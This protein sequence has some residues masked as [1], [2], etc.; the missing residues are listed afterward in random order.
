[1]SPL[2]EEGLERQNARLLEEARRT[3]ARLRE[4]E[5][6]YRTLVMATSQI[7]WSADADGTPRGEH[8][9]W[10]DL[11]GITL[12]E[13]RRGEWLEAIHP[14]DRDRLTQTWEAALA[15]ARAYQLEF[16]VRTAQGPYRW[17][18]VRGVPVLNDDG[19]IREWIGTATDIDDQRHRDDAASFLADASALLAASLD[20][21]TILSRLAWLAVPRLA[22]WCAID[23]AR[24]N[25][26]PER[27]IIAHPDRAKAAMITEIDRDYPLPLGIDPITRVITSGK[28]FLVEHA[29]PKFVETFAQDERHL[30]I[31][32]ALGVRSWLIVPIV[33][34][35]RT[36]GSLS[37]LHTDSG[38]S[39]TERDL[40]MIED[41]VRRV[42]VA[43]HNAV[44]Y[45]EAQTANRAKDEFLATL[46][47]ELRTPMT[48][49]VGW[50]R[51]L[52]LGELDPLLVRE[53][54][55]AIARGAKTQAQLIDDIL[56]VSRITLGKL[57]LTIDEVDVNEIVSNAVEAVSAT[58][59]LKGIAIDV[60]LDLSQPRIAG[61]VN[62]LQQVVWNLVNNAVKFT[63][64]GGQVDVAVEREGEQVRVSVDDSGPGIAAEFLPYLFDRFR[65]ADSTTTR[66]HGGLGLGLSIVKQLAELHGGSVA[67]TSPGPRGG[68]SFTVTIPIGRS[69]AIQG[70]GRAEAAIAGMPQLRGV[71]VLVVDDDAQ[72]RRFI[73]AALQR[74][75]AT[76][77]DAATVEEAL[78]ALKA[79]TPAVVVTDIAMPG[80]DGYDLLG[81]IRTVLHIDETD[82]PVIAITAFV[83]PQD[84]DRILNA[85]FHR[86]ISKPLDPV[87]L[88]KAVA[89]V[90]EVE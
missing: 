50:A 54:I 39:F 71:Q 81:D 77:R 9:G 72:T 83:G 36:Y 34:G 19:T 27:L 79:K 78:N 40:P 3:A 26:R 22:D 44:L 66:R 43:V 37:L 65:Q 84:R 48:A 24:E 38:R 49:I 42:G 67:V 88:A 7:V 21:D 68:A 18:S 76:V 11:M 61:D 10:R 31:I 82:L 63:P 75:G 62:R 35:G 13:S 89:A 32:R 55:Q 28:P 56:D 2:S 46:S 8:A 59:T 70:G 17:F 1:M 15:G 53:G 16:R 57:H 14:E 64:N 5:E 12:D 52:E 73:V 69:E 60:R 20:P 25:S 51:M 87:D 45:V 23:V 4:E 30:E 86:Y 47:H 80:R 41:L 29:D 85:G 58:A 90:V 6:R 74:A 33:S